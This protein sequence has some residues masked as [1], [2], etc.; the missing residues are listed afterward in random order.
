MA[1][2][3]EKVKLKL[4]ELDQL[5]AKKKITAE[6]Y[7]DLKTDLELQL[8]EKSAAV[9]KKV[10]EHKVLNIICPNCGSPQKEVRSGVE[11][12][13]CEMCGK[14]VKRFDAEREAAR[15]LRKLPELL[16]HVAL[17]Q[18]FIEPQKFKIGSGIQVEMAMEHLMKKLSPII[19]ESS[20][21]SKGDLLNICCASLYDAHGFRFLD[22]ITAGSIDKMILINLSELIDATKAWVIVPFYN[23][24]T[25]EQQNPTLSPEEYKQLRSDM[26]YDDQNIA[27]WS[28][29]K[30]DDILDKL[31][32]VNRQKLE[33]ALAEAKAK[34]GPDLSER[35]RRIK[36]KRILIKELNKLQSEYA[37]QTTTQ[38]LIRKAGRGILGSIISAGKKEEPKEEPVLVLPWNQTGSLETRIKD[39]FNIVKPLN[40]LANLLAVI[41]AYASDLKLNFFLSL[42]VTPQR[43][44][45]LKN[46]RLKEEQ[47]EIEKGEA[48]RAAQQKQFG[49]FPPICWA[50]FFK[51]LASYSEGYGMLLSL[52][53]ESIEKNT[54]LKKLQ[55]S[56]AI[57]NFENAS[58]AFER[59]IQNA[60]KK[61]EP[62][63]K[64]YS[65]ASR[66]LAQAL[67][68]TLPAKE[69]AAL[70]A[71]KT[72]LIDVKLEKDLIMLNERCFMEK[73]AFSGNVVEVGG[74][75]N[76]GRRWINQRIIGLARMI[77]GP[78]FL[79]FLDVLLIR[80]I[81]SR[82][83][84]R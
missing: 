48:E 39:C 12:F 17:E 73:D 9:A 27:F 25:K 43:A 78:R 72:R 54:P 34:L 45:I 55:L 61:R 59:V 1:T 65:R 44:Q 33:K 79:F 71:E 62:Y 41:S 26:K 75:I 56:E 69:I 57:V 52:K 29:S 47:T 18:L 58:A 21:L 32:T 38:Y 10:A 51:A 28:R 6:K 68:G 74:Y 60:D 83:K 67:K 11:E 36:E 3:A 82:A 30:I 7:L 49:L 19:S 23:T 46:I 76:E 2:K 37:A 24:V 53:K 4:K 42:V 50:N 15:L 5:L 80:D 81:Q 84:K 8:K 20:S 13:N 31:G 64:F 22:A 77:E 63:L 66:A 16:E 35:D 14:L 70:E 40:D